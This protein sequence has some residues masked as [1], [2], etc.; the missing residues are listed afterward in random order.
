MHL[1]VFGRLQLDK[2][3]KVRSVKTQTERLESDLGVSI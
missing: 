2:G 3:F 1:L